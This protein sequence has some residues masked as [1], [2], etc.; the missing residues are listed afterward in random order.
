[1]CI[2][3]DAVSS[4]MDSSSKRQRISNESSPQP[5][6]AASPAYRSDA[7][8]PTQELDANMTG[9]PFALKCQV[10]EVS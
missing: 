1:M 4:V 9:M 3:I 7:A 6:V 10:A 5:Q 2:S 8:D